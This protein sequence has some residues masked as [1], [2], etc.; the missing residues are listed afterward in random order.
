M[1]NGL[2]YIPK[3]ASQ[4]PSP[5][6]GSH[7]LPASL[8]SLVVVGLLVSQLVLSTW[9]T[10]TLGLWTGYECPH[11]LLTTEERRSSVIY[12][13][14]HKYS[15]GSLTTHCLAKQYR[16]LPK[17]CDI[18]SCGLLT[19][20]TVPGLHWFW[21]KRPH[22]QSK[23][24]GCHHMIFVPRSCQRLH[25]AWQVGTVAFRIDWR[26]KYH[27]CISFLA[28]CSAPL[29]PWKIV[30]MKEVFRSVAAWFLCVLQVCCVFSNRVLPTSSRG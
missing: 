22:I 12:R 1:C 24:V 15:E 10:L 29:G 3:T 26:N 28:A 27:L 11:S 9:Q 13:Y 6:S 23:A 2:Y 8:L 18:P 4:Q 14:K 30:T 21:W 16:F 17:T 7:I 25:L 20:F 19:R 5:F